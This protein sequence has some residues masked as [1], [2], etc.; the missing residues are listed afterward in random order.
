MAR[1]RARAPDRAAVEPD[2][3]LTASWVDAFLRAERL[4]AAY[5]ASIEEVHVPLARRIGLRAAQA[6]RRPWIVGLC[7]PQ[8]SDKSTLAASLGHL[9]GAQG[10]RTAVL[11][12][13]DLYLTRAQRADLA[14]RVHPLLR[15]RGVPGTHDVALGLEL[16]AALRRGAPVALPRFD[17]SR[18]ERMPPEAWPRLPGAIDVLLFE[19]WCV[20]ARPQPDVELAVPLNAVERDEDPEGNWRR[21]VNATLAGDYQHLFAELDQL[22]LLRADGFEQVLAWRVEQE[23]KLRA[24][25]LTSGADLAATLDDAQLARFIQLFER[26]TRHMLD[27]MPARADELIE[28]QRA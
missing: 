27:E 4:P 17:K 11:S 2:E 7:G 22:V 6:A 26:L 16:F 12:L 15:E 3:I 8:G 13:D 28:A 10:L 25:L 1:T 23:H 20:G 18:D 21:Y 9:L 24:R 19:G 14:R 5:R